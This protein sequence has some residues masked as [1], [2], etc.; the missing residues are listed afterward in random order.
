M[1]PREEGETSLFHLH[2]EV[3][4]PAH[5]FKV[6]RVPT[7]LCRGYEIAIL[8]YSPPGLVYRE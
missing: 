3:L 1:D 4:A 2:Q 6:V 7:T 8:D 5:A